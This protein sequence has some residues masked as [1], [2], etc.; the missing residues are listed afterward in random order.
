MNKEKL[1]QNIIKEYGNIDISD[2]SINYRAGGQTTNVN[3]LGFEKKTFLNLDDTF[4][5]KDIKNKYYN[6]KF[7]KYPLDFIETKKAQFFKYMGSNA[8]KP[9]AHGCKHPDLV[10]ID[11]LNKK[12]FIIEIKF[13]TTSGS[14]CEK[15]Q[16]ALFKKDYYNKI[17]HHYTV[18]YIFVLNDWFEQHCQV[19]IKWLST[20]EIPVIIAKPHTCWKDD[21]I[22]LMHK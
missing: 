7:K 19:E 20:L 22:K 4:E 6:V 18:H 11:E 3:G 10:Y 21:L 1:L 14:V 5:Y 13:Q 9:Q 12:I 15:L 16:S 8:E 17:I 2:K